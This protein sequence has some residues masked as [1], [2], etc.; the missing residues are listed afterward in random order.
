MPKIKKMNF[1]TVLSGI[2]FLMSTSWGQSTQYQPDK[3]G[4]FIIDNQLNKCPDLN[5]ND[6]T[7]KLTS[8]VDWVRQNNPVMNPPV[9]FDAVTNFSGNLCNEVIGNEAFGIQSRIYFSLRYYYIENGVSKTTTDWAAHGTEIIFNN[10]TRFISTQFDETGVRTDDPPYLKQPLKMALENLKKYYTIDPVIKE[11]APGVRLYAPKSGTWFAGTIIV[12][13]PDRPEI[14]I[15]VSVKEIMEARLAYYSIKQEIDSINYEKTKAQWAKMNFKPA[16]GQSMQPMLY[17]VIKNEYEKFTIEELN[18]PAFLSSDEQFG[19][20]MVNASGNGSPVDRFNPACWDRSLPV[21]AI[22]FISTEYR[23][24][25]TV[26]LEEFKQRNGGLTD[27]V[28]LFFN[29]MPVEKMG[30]L[31]QRHTTGAN[32]R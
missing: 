20:S 10:P 4:K 25:T 28:G 32:S 14:W 19:V 6:V 7:L 8:F 1:L 22:Q 11:I 3:H 26:E 13:N 24:A 17:D 15:P 2:T 23:P 21:T 27:Y 12:L 29:S 31:I 30:D 5:V 16:P 9:G 18:R